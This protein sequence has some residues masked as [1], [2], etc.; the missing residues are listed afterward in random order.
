MPPCNCGW[1]GKEMTGVT[2]NAPKSKLLLP[3]Q[4]TRSPSHRGMI[5]PPHLIAIVNTNLFRGQNSTIC[6]ST[7]L[8]NENLSMCVQHTYLGAYSW[9]IC[10]LGKGIYL[11]PWKSKMLH[12]ALAIGQFRRQCNVYD[13]PR[14]LTLRNWRHEYSL[15]SFIVCTPLDMHKMCIM[16]YQ[17]TFRFG[18]YW[19]IFNQSDPYFPSQLSLKIAHL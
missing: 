8:G 13:S 15:T 3:H 4:V 17:H 1:K 16:L 18:P 9:F 12:C 2:H 7:T 11:T 14:L 6:S 5:P 19:G 10:Q